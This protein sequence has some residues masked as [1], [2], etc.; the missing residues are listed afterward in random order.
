MKINCVDLWSIESD[1]RSSFLCLL[2]AMIGNTIIVDHVINALKH[3]RSFLWQE[4]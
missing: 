2:V 3:E 4:T 1:K